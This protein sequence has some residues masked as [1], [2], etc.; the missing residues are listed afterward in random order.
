MIHHCK[1][2][3]RG[4]KTPFLVA[5]MPFG[6]YHISISDAVRNAV[7]LVQ[8]GGIECVKLEGGVEVIPTVKT[9]TSVGIPVMAHIGLL[10]QRHVS[11]SGYK[12]QG[13]K[14]LAAF[15]ILQAARGLQD[16]G[17]CS[18]VLEAVPHA[19]ASHITKDLDIP[20]IGIGAG[21]GCSGQ[22]LVWDDTMGAWSGHQAKFVRRFAEL[23]ARASEGVKAYVDAVRARS[24]PL[25]DKEGYEMPEEEWVEFL[26]LCKRGKL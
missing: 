9:L 17:A 26:E 23:G 25:A 20:T 21:P 13:K 19:L 14:A 11:M 6:T 3:A 22:V 16:A 18:I 4:C 8:E 1:A 24:F 10:P 12:V 5:D 7:R 2:V 15:N